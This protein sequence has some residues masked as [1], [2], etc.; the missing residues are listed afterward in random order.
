MPTIGKNAAKLE[1]LEIARQ[2]LKATFESTLGNSEWG[3]SAA[4]IALQ[5]DEKLADELFALTYAKSRPRADGEQSWIS[6]GPYASARAQKWPGEARILIEREWPK[7]LA[8][9]KKPRDNNDWDP[10]ENGARQLIDAMAHVS[11]T[12]AVEM[13]REFPEK[14]TARAQALGDVAEVLL[15]KK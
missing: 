12:R 1:Q 7:R 13:A 5:F 9:A 11:P 8:N 3:A 10:S 6:V 14:S 2:A 15:G 4:Q